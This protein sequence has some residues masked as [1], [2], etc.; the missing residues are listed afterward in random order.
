MDTS[1]CIAC[2]MTWEWEATALGEQLDTQTV[3]APQA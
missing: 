3:M 1:V 2:G